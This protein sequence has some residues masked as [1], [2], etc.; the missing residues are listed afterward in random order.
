ME[1]RRNV[2]GNENET[3]T[4]HKEE[5]GLGFLWKDYLESSLRHYHGKSPG[6]HET[7]ADTICKNL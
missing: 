1:T 3:M 5:K 7:F 6:K 2:N 4:F